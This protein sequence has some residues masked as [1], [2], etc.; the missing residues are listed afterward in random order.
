MYGLRCLK[1]AKAVPLKEINV[2]VDIIG[3]VSNVTSSLEYQNEKDNPVEAVFV[4]P[5]DESSAVYKFEALIEG[6]RVI[7]KVKEKQKAREEYDDAI[8]SGE[9]AFLLEE[10]DRAGDVFKCSVGNLP[11]KTS[12]T[13]RLSYVSE[14]PV[15]ADSSLK[16]VLP[17][18]LNPRYSSG[19]EAAVYDDTYM[20]GPTADVL[21]S[22]LPYVLKL[23]VI[24]SSPNSIDKI[25]S[26]KSSLDVTYGGTSAQVTLKDDHKFDSDV[27]LYVHYK[28]KHRPFAVTEL[29]QGTEGF[30]ADH[31]VMLTFV[32]DLSRDDLVTT[33]G[34]FI[35]ILDRSGSMSGSNIKNARETLL[36]FLKSLPIGCYFNIVG[37]GSSY[38]T[39]FN[40]SQKYD[41][42]SLKT[43]C[44]ALEKMEADLGGTEILQPL[45]FVYK[46]PAIEGHPRQ[47][48]L[49]TDGDVWD[50]QACVSEVAKHADS[51]RCFSV[52]IGEGASTALVKGVARAGR[53]KAEFVSGTDRLQAKVMRLLSCAL[54]PTVTG[55]S[56]TWQLPDGVTAVPIPSTP[57]PIFSGDRF[58][59]YAQLQGQLP[60]AGTEGSVTLS[61]QV[62]QEEIKHTLNLTLQPQDQD[63]P[64][65]EDSPDPKQLH[66]LAA[67]TLVK[68][69]EVKLEK[70][71]DNTGSDSDKT[72]SDSAKKQIV[73]L[74]VAA[75]VVSKF[76]SFIG[77]DSERGEPIEGAMIRRHIPRHAP[78]MNCISFGMSPAVAFCAGPMAMAD[79]YDECDY[80]GSEDMEL[81]C[82]TE[83]MGLKSEESKE[84][85]ASRIVGS[86][87]GLFSS[88]ASGGFFG[89]LRRLVGGGPGPGAAARPMVFAG[90]GIRGGRIRLRGGGGGPNP[91]TAR[92]GK[93]AA[94]KAAPQM[95]KAKSM[96]RTSS[97]KPARALKARAPA[98][99]DDDDDDDD[100][101]E[102]DSA[103]PSTVIPLQMAEGSWELDGHLAAV[104]GLE[105]DRLKKEC[106]VQDKTVWAT[107]LALVWLH[108]KMA[109]KKVEWQM[110]ARKATAWLKSHQQG[111]SADDVVGKACSI[112][113]A[114]VDP[115]AIVG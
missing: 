94:M 34:E 29:G 55:V 26:P 31:T 39:L 111:W 97:G 44:K 25:E 33:C 8:A 14:L 69:L 103:T 54:Q 51:A 18:V 19:T 82:C 42:K 96:P 64:G 36:L 99:D 105:L 113:G 15:E 70:D 23:K 112:L 12:A 110:L 76:T 88:G 72:V 114:K 95:K 3:Y 38:K 102:E 43:A 1:T 71:G 21:T 109:D 75:N 40:N 59:M 98:Y 37:F 13:V 50:T 5:L 66:R 58:I 89:G 48:F 101:S 65:A 10:D 83:T 46:Q 20:A 22:D 93:R 16:F 2:Q 52:G 115:S 67:K 73:D 24:V 77:V 7:G 79:S 41:N 60:V 104:L 35:F 32:P 80:G 6:R 81:E 106:P 28:D 45:Q 30:M 68:E 53:G 56:L 61:G 92:S 90:G 78:L 57:P 9:G 17:T 87:K 100:D 63:M 11:P 85:I 27:E 108:S 47:L 49:L 84:G 91:N 4:F 107:V 74:S 62:L 86:V